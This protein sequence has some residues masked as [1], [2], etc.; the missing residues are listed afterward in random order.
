[1]F[2]LIEEL[3]NTQTITSAA[4]TQIDELAQSRPAR[5][6]DKVTRSQASALKSTVSGVDWSGILGLVEKFVNIADTIAE[7]YF[8][9]FVS[10]GAER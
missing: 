5:V 7:V 8:E 4:R 1:M 3:T 10:G 9:S 6:I 2:I